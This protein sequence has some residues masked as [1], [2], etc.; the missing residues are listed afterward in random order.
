[1][2][3]EMKVLHYTAAA[4]A[5]GGFYAVIGLLVWTFVVLYSLAATLVV[6]LRFFHVATFRMLG[7]LLRASDRYRDVGVDAEVSPDVR[8]THAKFTGRDSSRA[9]R[10]A[11]NVAPFDAA[12]FGGRR[13]WDEN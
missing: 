11:G 10:P 2:N 8:A 9:G 7:W 12:S 1:M 5:R 6:G 3:L 13:P 4:L